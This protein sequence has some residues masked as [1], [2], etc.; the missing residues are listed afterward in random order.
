M[1]GSELGSQ[2]GNPFR[3]VEDASRPSFPDMS[4]DR[5]YQ[6]DQ[7]HQREYHSSRTSSSKSSKRQTSSSRQS[8]SGSLA[9][10]GSEASAAFVGAQ[11]QEATSVA[12]SSTSGSRIKRKPLKKAPDAPVRYGSVRTELGE[13]YSDAHP[14]LHHLY[15]PPPSLTR[16]VQKSVHLFRSKSHGFVEESAHFYPRE[17]ESSG[18]RM[19]FAV[20][21]LSARI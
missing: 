4:R 17:D 20:A 19:V 7:S 18:R 15:T 16:Q 10:A 3:P 14:T 11:H 12:A 2:G 9:S 21:Q 8:S 5:G 13:Y 1:M 6:Y